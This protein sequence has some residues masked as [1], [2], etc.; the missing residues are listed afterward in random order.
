[1]RFRGWVTLLSG[2]IALLTSAL[3][4]AAAQ[5]KTVTVRGYVLDSAC[6]YTKSLKKPISAECAKACAK[7]G[8]PLVILADDGSI[9]WPTTDAMPATSQ[10]EKLLPF[11]A[12]RVVASGKVYERGGSRALVITKVE[13]EK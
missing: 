7:G 11:A 8:S 13:A 3:L 10:N 5:P 4:F 2:W 12:Q 9:Y 1:M 6:A